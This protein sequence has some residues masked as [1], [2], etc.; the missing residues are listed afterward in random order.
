MKEKIYSEPKAVVKKFRFLVL[1]ILAISALI[2]C[3]GCETSHDE[4]PIIAETSVQNSETTSSPIIEPV[5]TLNAAESIILGDWKLYAITYDIGEDR[6]DATGYV[7][8]NDDYTGT[9]CI[10]NTV[11]NIKWKYDGRIDQDYVF[12]A[13][14]DAKPIGSFTIAYMPDDGFLVLGPDDNTYAIYSREGYVEP[15][16]H[17]MESATESS[18]ETQLSAGQR[19]ALRQAQSYITVMAF[20]RSGLI[21]QLEYSGYSSEDA[22]FAVDSLNVNWKEQAILKAKDYIDTMAFSRMGLIDQLE[23]SG[24]TTEEATYGVDSLTIDWKEQAYKKAL[25]YLDTMAFSY[26]SLVDQLEYSGFT[27]EEAKYGATKAYN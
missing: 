7:I 22:T 21:D 18:Q 3:T 4:T 12:T 19:N 8:I 16:T 10:D 14:P 15:N 5:N 6:W 26:S 25:S 1:L 13:Y 23:Y 24:F 20:S 27:S 17:V 2:L 9:Y 11:V